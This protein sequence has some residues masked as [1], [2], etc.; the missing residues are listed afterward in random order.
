ML[1][2]YNHTLMEIE[3]VAAVLSEAGFP[4]SPADARAMPLASL[5]RV[6][7]EAAFELPDL[8]ARAPAK[9]ACLAALVSLKSDANAVLA[10]RPQGARGPQDVGLQFA[11]VSLAT[12]AHMRL[13]QEGGGLARRDIDA[14][15]WAKAG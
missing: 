10:V 5:K 9:A 1:F 2:L 13:M 11:D 12:M 7:Q 8:E 4:L 6:L 3:D 15:V 14:A